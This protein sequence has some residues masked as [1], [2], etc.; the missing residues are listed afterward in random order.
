[1]CGIIGYS[2]KNNAKDIIIDGLHALEYRGYDSAGITVFENNR[3]ITVKT[4]GRVNNLGRKTAESIKGIT[5]CGIGHTRWATHGEPSEKNAHPHGNDTLMLVHNGIIENSNELKDE[6]AENGYHF[7]SDTDTE[8]I[9]AVIEKEYRQCGDR[10]KSVIKACDRLRGSFALGIVFSDCPDT[11]FATGKDSPLLIGNS[12]HGNFIASDISAFIC[13]T[14]TYCRLK[15]YETAVICK[16]NVIII[17]RDGTEHAPEWQNAEERNDTADC[18]GFRHFMLK[19]IYDEP[20]AMKK[21]YESVTTEGL[22]DF[23]RTVKDDFFTK[24]NRIH[25]TA[26]GTAYH[27]GLLGGKFI[28]KLARIPV[29][30]HIASEFRYADPVTDKNDLAIIISQSGETADSLAALRLMKSRNIRNVSVVNTT[31]ST[32]ENESDC[33]IRTRAGTEISVASTKAFHVQVLTL[34]LIATELALINGK[35][36]E[37][38]VRKLLT[39]TEND[40]THNIPQM[41]QKNNSILPVAEKLSTHKSVFFIGRGTDSILATEASLKL[42]E[43]SY[44]NSQAYPAGELKHG[45][46]SLIEKGTPVIAIATD[47][48]FFDKM[49]S[50][51]REVKARGAHVISICPGNAQSV[52]DVS[53]E[54]ILLPADTCSLIPFSA[55]T[56]IQLLAYHTA[57]ALGRDIDKPRNLAKSVT[58]E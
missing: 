32:M 38:E 47:S 58:V 6:F 15:D 13:H 11:V 34:L 27:A 7:Y 26:C 28:E 36:S 1:M 22:P 50:N 39:A 19:E 24:I 3:L 31:G 42:K 20:D 2:G 18:Y 17:N 14:D 12:S 8:V 23:S 4:T 45:T 57:N 40:F 10:V 55:S 25:I 35:M 54:V 41:L 43:I 30:V 21:T 48:L 44:I 49:K 56:V 46:I 5:T 16:D 33:I 9:A 37:D 52:Q 29:Q 51:I 53:D